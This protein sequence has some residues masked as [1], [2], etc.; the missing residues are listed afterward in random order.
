MKCAVAL[1]GLAVAGAALA[2]APAPA[3]GGVTAPRGMPEVSGEL[4]DPDFGVRRRAAGLQRKVEMYQWRR[5]G[6]RYGAG[7]SQERIDSSAFD[8]AHAN[9][10]DFPVATRYWIATRVHLD[11]K[12]VSD[13]VLKAHGT[14]RAFRPGFS[15]LPGNLSATFQPEGD[16]L[17]S[18]ENPLHPQVGD[19]RITWHALE[20]P[21]LDG[22][23]ALEN[24]AWVPTPAPG[25]VAGAAVARAAPAAPVEAQPRRGGMARWHWLVALASGAALLVVWMRVRRR[26]A[27]P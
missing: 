7:W 9:P 15:S 18:S 11:G 27:R 8:R 3:S 25:P 12:P 22:K 19:L 23:V 20:L 5:E 24:G 6:A 2:Q 16:G 13:D 21:P 4:R 26:R 17:S 14:W 1:V 10:D